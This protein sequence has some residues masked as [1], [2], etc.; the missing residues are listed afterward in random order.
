MSNREAPHLTPLSMRELPHP[1]CSGWSLQPSKPYSLPSALLFIL[2]NDE[3]YTLGPGHYANS[4]WFLH[5]SDCTAHLRCIHSHSYSDANDVSPNRGT[6]GIIHTCSA[7]N[8][9]GDRCIALPA[10]HPSTMTDCKGATWAR[11]SSPWLM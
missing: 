7:A 8:A 10:G 5:T 9:N 2:Q 3:H 11:A 4:V 1:F 6:F